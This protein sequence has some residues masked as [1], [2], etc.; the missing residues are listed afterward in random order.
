MIERTQDYRIINRMVG[1]K[2][3]ISN[4]CI[5]LAEKESADVRG[6]W[7]FEPHEDGVRIHADMG[8][9]ARGKKAIESAKR[10]FN[11]IFGNTSYRKIFAGIPT[12]N[13]PACRVA[14]L[15]GMRYVGFDEKLRWFELQQGW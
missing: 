7:S 14:S 15:S 10:A 2:P 11:W 13:R 9:K 8:P 5:Y 3:I 4:K 6:I 1:F 12:E